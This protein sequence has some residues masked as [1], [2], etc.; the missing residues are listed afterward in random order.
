MWCCSKK[1]LSSVFYLDSL[2]GRNKA[3]PHCAVDATKN[4]AIP[5][6]YCALRCSTVSAKHPAAH[7]AIAVGRILLGVL[8]QTFPHMHISR[9]ERCCRALR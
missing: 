2:V 3:R 7:L 6:G 1:T 9:I 4:G 5:S 8:S